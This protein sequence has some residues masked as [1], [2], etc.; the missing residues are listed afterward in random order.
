MNQ[1]FSS[2]HRL[3]GMKE[4]GIAKHRVKGFLAEGVMAVGR[5]I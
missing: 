2:F 1:L 5:S 4:A 3:V